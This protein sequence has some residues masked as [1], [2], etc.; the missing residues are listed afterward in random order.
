APG[1]SFLIIWYDP[2]STER[3]DANRTPSA[4][5][6]G[7]AAQGPR[8][9]G[10]GLPLGRGLGGAPHR[11]PP[12]L[13]RRH[14]PRGPARLP[15][16][17]PDGAVPAPTRTHPQPGTTPAA[18]GPT[19]RVVAAAAHLDLSPV[20]RG[21]RRGRPALEPAA[22]APLPAA[23]AGRLSA[24]RFHGTAQTRPRQGRTGQ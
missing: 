13:L 4:P 8:S 20:E 5:P 18:P 11:H 2:H 16:A 3:F 9:P 7:A 23:A 12:G 22:T 1:R 21:P 15:P 14:R 24:H 19:D 17:R 10:D 6:P